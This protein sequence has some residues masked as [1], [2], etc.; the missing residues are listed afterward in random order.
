MGGVVCAVAAAT[1][2]ALCHRRCVLLAA[3][4]CGEVPPPG[5]NEKPGESKKKEDV[6]DA[7]FTDKNSN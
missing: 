1:A 5:D 3:G 4:P 2:C 6:V 7:D